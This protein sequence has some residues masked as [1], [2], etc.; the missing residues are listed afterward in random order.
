VHLL[1]ILQ[2]NKRCTLQGITT[3]EAQQAKIYNYKNTK[4]KLLKTNA[5]MWLNKLCKTKQLTPKYFK[6]KIK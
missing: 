2:N 4:L 6:I 1:V 3:I 5:A